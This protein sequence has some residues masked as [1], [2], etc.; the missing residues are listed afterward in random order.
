MKKLLLLIAI[1]TASMQLF[2]QHSVGT[3][4]LQPKAGVNIS[5]MQKGGGAKIGFVG[6]LEGEYQLTDM[7]SMSAGVIYSQQ[8]EKESFYYNTSWDETYKYDYINVPIMANVYVLK[9]FAVK[10]GVQPGFLVHDNLNGTVEAKSFDFSIPV[11]LSY[12]YKNIVLDARYIH[13]LTKVANHLDEKNSLFQF[14]LGY[15]FEL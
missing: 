10:L 9:G 1:V 7:V 3:F 13:G 8:G 6:G 15:K 2:A 14:T 11:G 5:S 12:E 4:T